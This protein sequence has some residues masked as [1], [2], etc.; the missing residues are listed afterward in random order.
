MIA[1]IIIEKYSSSRVK[2]ENKWS[3]IHVVHQLHIMAYIEHINAINIHARCLQESSFSETQ[4]TQAH[5][6]LLTTEQHS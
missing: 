5:H 4:E 1:N 6:F 2:K 3:I